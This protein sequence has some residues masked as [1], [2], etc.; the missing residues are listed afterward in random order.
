V[1]PGTG[2]TLMNRADPDQVEPCGLLEIE[3]I[4]QCLEMELPSLI[5]IIPP[6]LKN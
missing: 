5:P 6:L 1:K 3:L 2:R 4:F